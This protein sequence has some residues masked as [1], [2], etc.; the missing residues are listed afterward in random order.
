VLLAVSGWAVVRADVQPVNASTVTA[1]TTA[2]RWLLVTTV[3]GTG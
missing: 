3:T 1:A 2:A